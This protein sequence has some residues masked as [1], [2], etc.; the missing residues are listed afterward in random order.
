MLSGSYDLERGM[1]DTRDALRAITESIEHELKRLDIWDDEKPSPAALRS[2]EPFCYDTLGFAEWMQWVFLPRMHEVL[3]RER[4]M[5][6]RSNI[7]AYAEEV[8]RNTEHDADQL[9]FLIK[10]FDEVVGA[11]GDGADAAPN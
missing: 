9:L 8:L 11:A 6:D 10:T 1:P 2:P 3:A 5:P 7:H 4:E